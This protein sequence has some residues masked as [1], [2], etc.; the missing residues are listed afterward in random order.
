MHVLII[1]SWFPAKYTPTSGLYFYDQLNA[2]QQAGHQVGVVYPE[3]HSVRHASSTALVTHHFQSRWSVEHGIPVLRKHSW[4]VRSRLQGTYAARIRDAEQLAER[5]AATFGRPDVVHAMS[6]Q[7]AGEAAARVASAWNRPMALTEHFS[8]F[9]RESLFPEQ[10]TF[11]R[12]AFARA[13]AIAAVS[14]HLRTTLD[15]QGWCDASRIALIPNPID[16]TFFRPPPTRPKQPPLICTA[17]GRLVPEKG[18][19]LLLH[20]M[21]NAFSRDA[22]VELHIGGEGPEENALR[23]LAARLG[24]NAQVTFHGRLSRSEVRNL[25]QQAH[26]F[27]LPSRHET[28]GLVIPEALATGCPVL[29]TRCGGPEYTMTEETGLLVAPDSVT[30]LAQG[31][32]TVTSR[33]NMYSAQTMRDVACNRFGAATFTERTVSMY[34]EAARSFSSG[35]IK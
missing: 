35:Y 19:D 21:A 5:Y 6:T 11:A 28:F 27:V 15:R 24:I 18:F 32:R 12:K 20:A 16:C 14:P 4:N 23:T 13:N 9:A 30:A 3:H 17:I 34:R 10:Q 1:P 33:L 26:L 2:L 8:G 25:L 7:W 22:Q 29:A 31:L